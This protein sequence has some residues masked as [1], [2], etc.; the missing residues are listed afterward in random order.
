MRREKAKCSEE[1]I[2][3]SGPRWLV[4]STPVLP[5]WSS[6]RGCSPGSTVTESACPRWA[7]ALALMG[8]RDFIKFLFMVTQFLYNLFGPKP[9]LLSKW[10]MLSIWSMNPFMRPS[11]IICDAIFSAC[12]KTKIRLYTV[13]PESFHRASLFPHFVMLQPY[14]K[15]D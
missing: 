2:G 12:R 9:N 8:K 15:M 3:S 5:D 1:F 13:H 10:T 4:P 11:V 7:T 6:L 14:S